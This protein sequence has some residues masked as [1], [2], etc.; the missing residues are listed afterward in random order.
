MS[1]RTV[2]LVDDDEAIRHSASFMLRHA[3]FT[4]R[5]FPDGMTFL[6]AVSDTQQGCIL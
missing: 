5:T 1:D 6:D 4:V 2:F 3:G